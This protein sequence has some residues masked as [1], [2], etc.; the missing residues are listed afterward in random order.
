MAMAILASLLENV[1]NVPFGKND[2]RTAASLKL[3]GIDV[4]H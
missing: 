1:V 4:T 3:M 2:H